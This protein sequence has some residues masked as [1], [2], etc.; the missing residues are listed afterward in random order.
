VARAALI[1]SPPVLARCLAL[2]GQL[3]RGLFLLALFVISAYF[4]FST[5]VRRG[6]LAVPDLAGLDQPSAR[7]RLAESG[8]LL[9]VAEAGRWSAEVEAGRV[10]DTRPRAGSLVKRGAEIEVVLS[11]GARK[12]VLPDL[13][14]KALAAARLVLENE[15]LT[16]GP[17]LQIATDRGAPGSVVGQEPAPGVELA[18]GAKVALLVALD[19]SPVAWVMPDLVARRY[20]PVRAALEGQGFRFGS[21]T[22]EPYEGVAAGTVLRQA[23]LPG[24]PLRR[25]DSIA[26]VVASE[27]AGALP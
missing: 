2:A 22:F 20:E 14:G 12:I 6:V 16:V 4:A 1:D 15:G 18:P 19:A 10:L 11:L 8:L 23:P 5:W 21:V 27:G 26:L 24:H 13:A 17:A 9:A 3:A 7:E 25:T